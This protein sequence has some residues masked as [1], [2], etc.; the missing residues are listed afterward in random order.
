MDEIVFGVRVGTKKSFP[1]IDRKRRNVHGLLLDRIDQMTGR[2][3]DP[4]DTRFFL[5]SSSPFF[6][7]FRKDL[8]NDF[9]TMLRKHRHRGRMTGQTS[10]LFFGCRI[11]LQPQ[12]E[13]GFEH[14]R[15][16]GRPMQQRPIHAT[17]R[18]QVRGLLTHPFPFLIM[19]VMTLLAMLGREKDFFNFLYP[20]VAFSDLGRFLGVRTWEYATHDAHHHQRLPSP[21]KFFPSFS[22]AK[23][24]H[25]RC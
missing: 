7:G 20:F 24:C 22:V 21:H 3:T 14:R 1:C 10:G 23:H 4:F 13:D 15:R 2:T 5:R 8:C 19:T 11:G 16:Q 12:T 6:G 17:K 25:A 9:F 18:F